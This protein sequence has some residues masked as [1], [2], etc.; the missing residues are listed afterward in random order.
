MLELASLLISRHFS[1]VE[2]P[3]VMCPH[4]PSGISLEPCGSSWSQGIRWN[5][6]GLGLLQ[7]RCARRRVRGQ[8]E[9]FVCE[10][11][12]VLESL[13]VDMTKEADRRLPF[14]PLFLPR[15]S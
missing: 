9:P 15:H 11:G 5:S 2:I 3:R 14:S 7:A 8:R 10:C 6:R 4:F 12:V 13:A 1:L